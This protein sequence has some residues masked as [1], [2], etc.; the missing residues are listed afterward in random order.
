MKINKALE[1][2]SANEILKA[3]GITVIEIL[4]WLL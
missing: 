1:G 3:A 4:S 2:K